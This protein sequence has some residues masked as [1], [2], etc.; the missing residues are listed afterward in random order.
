M[1]RLGKKPIVLGN[2]VEA[3]ITSGALTVKGPL[4]SLSRVFPPVVEVAVANGEVTTKLVS[5]NP[6]SLPLWG[7]V[8]SHIKNMV[9]GVTKGFEEKLLIEGIG[10]KADVKG[11]SLVMSLGFSHPVNVAVPSGLKITVDKNI[12]TIKGIDRELV[13][14]FAANI[15]AMKK[16]EPYKGKGIM[17]VGEKIRRKQGKKTV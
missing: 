2:K 15:R 17:Y 9:E 4:G 16:P 11:E 6:E 10:Y 12:I 5:N 3:S 14:R 13:S 7:T 1:S 8:A